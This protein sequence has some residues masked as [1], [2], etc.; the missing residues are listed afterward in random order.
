MCVTS[1]TT[2]T[3]ILGDD[4]KL[5]VDRMLAA[6]LPYQTGIRS[7]VEDERVP[8]PSR[9]KTRPRGIPVHHLC[10]ADTSVAAPESTDSPSPL[11]MLRSLRIPSEHCCSAG[12]ILREIRHQKF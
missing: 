10:E 1:R 11:G 2:N 8:S 6:R 3:A 5:N 7:A 4:C 9:N 12:R